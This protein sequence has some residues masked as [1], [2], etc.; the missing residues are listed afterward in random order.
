[1][2]WDVVCPP[3]AGNI[4]IDVTGNTLTLPVQPDS[5]FIRL[6]ASVAPSK[7][8]ALV[9][10]KAGVSKDKATHRIIKG[11]LL[12]A[13]QMVIPKGDY[14]LDARLVATLEENH[15][16]VRIGKLGFMYTQQVL[17]SEV[18]VDRIDEFEK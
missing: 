14:T 11:L 2:E 9:E 5:K 3:T 8:A 7:E 12:P 4:Q 15:N 1:M 10:L 18:T 17:K 13:T 16:S 6:P